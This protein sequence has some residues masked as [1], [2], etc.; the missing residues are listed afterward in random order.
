MKSIYTLVPDI[1]HLLKTKG[2]FIDS[3]PDEFAQEVTSRLKG[4]FNRPETKP[5]LRLSQM[6]DRCPCEL[7]HMINKPHLAEPLPAWAEMKFSFGHTIEGL[8]IALAKA[9]G[10]E[11]TG[12]QDEVQLDGVV[13]HRDCIID[14]CLVDVKSAAT[15]SFQKFK[16]GSIK[17]ND[18]FGYLSQLDGYLAASADDPALRVK[19]K[20]YLLAIDKQLGHM[21]LYEHKVREENIRKRI[22]LY[23]GIVALPSAPACTCCSVEDGKYGNLKLDTKASYNQYKYCCKPHLRTFLYSSGPRYLTKVVRTPDVPEI[24]RNGKIIRMP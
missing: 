7:W 20:G 15:L 16:D 9:A 6:G 4:Q 13:G 19:D 18:P 8:A 24:D 17:D 5:T 10:H 21:C 14:G 22:T 23:K 2:W 3:V 12:E 1:Q 11:V